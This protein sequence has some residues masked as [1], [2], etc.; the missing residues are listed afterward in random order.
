[1]FKVDK[2][3]QELIP[4]GIL[5]AFEIWWNFNFAPYSKISSTSGLM[6]ISM[7]SCAS[8]CLLAY[9]FASV[10]KYKNI[11]NLEYMNNFPYGDLLKVIFRLTFITIVHTAFLIAWYNNWYNTMNMHYLLSYLYFLLVLIFIFRAAN[12]PSNSIS[13]SQ[14][15][16][17]E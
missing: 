16:G 14:Q 1:M 2:L 5:A 7:K 8:I 9:L 15:Q 13:L 12:R 17:S 11:I 10:D 6:L 4:L 3:K